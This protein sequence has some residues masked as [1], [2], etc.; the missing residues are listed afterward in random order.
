MRGTF[1]NIRLK[2]KLAAPGTEGGWTKFF[3]T[4]DDPNSIYD[5]SMDYQ[6]S[7]YTAGGAFR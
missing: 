5:A 1:A 4:G 7:G 6:A 3:P 2:N